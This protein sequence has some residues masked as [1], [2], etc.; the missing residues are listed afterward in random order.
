MA[1]EESSLKQTNIKKGDE[2]Q[3]PN[4]PYYLHPGENINTL[5]VSPVLDGPNYHSWSKLMKRGLQSRNKYKFVDGTIKE[6]PA[7]DSLH[8]VWIRC[9][10]MVISWITRSVSLQIAQSIVY[11]DNAEDLWKDLRDRFSKGDHFRMSDLLQEIHSIKQ[12]ERTISTYHIDLKILWEELEILRPIPACSCTVK[13]TCELVKTVR[14]YKE[15]E[16]VICFLKGLNDSYNTVRSQ[17]LMMDPLPNINKVFSLVL[18]QERQVLGN[19]LQEVNLVASITNNKQSFGGRNGSSSGRGR[20]RFNQRNFSNQPQ[21]ICTFCGKERHTVETCY[22]K[23][24]FPP[25]FN[26]KNKRQT[27]TVNSYP[28]DSA[29][30]PTTVEGS[31]HKIIG[32]EYTEVSCT[33]T[34]KQY[35][36]LM[37]ILKGSNVSGETH[38]VDNL[39]QHPGNILSTQKEQKLPDNV[40]ILDSGATDHVSNSLSCYDSYN[41]I[42]PIRIKLPNG[43]ITQTQISGTVA[44]SGRFFLQDV[45][46][47]P[48]FNYNIISVG[49]IVKNFNCKIVFDKLCC[50]I[51]DHNNKLMIGPA[52]LQC[53]LYILQRQNFSENKIVNSARTSSDNNMNNSNF[54]LWHYR[55]GHPSDSVLQQ[56]KGQF[57]YVNLGH[58]SDSILQQIK[59]QFPYVKYDHKLVCDYCHLAKQC[60]LSFP[61]SINSTASCFYLMHMD[62]WVPLS[63]CSI[64]GHK[65]FHNL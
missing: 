55:L 22:F 63:I 59:G 65:Y 51:Q 9:N 18:Q 15:T 3:N 44:F 8:D 1:E 56:I 31:D 61:I 26:F 34:T 7:N 40:W 27:S 28:S 57:P 4:S 43:F 64:H 32:K 17:V 2:S 21:K 35:N 41:T 42:E 53:N 38:V 45:L 11:I 49:K 33:I 16:Y 13:C 48:D 10:T 58:P 20:G 23:H 54:D 6:P 62:I 52:N 19:L 25:N 29:P 46:Y 47:I 50:Y 60:K 39:Q 14:N 37:E 12:G 36:Q 30:S 5:T 24:G